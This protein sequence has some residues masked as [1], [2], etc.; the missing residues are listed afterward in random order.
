MLQPKGQL[1]RPPCQGRDV[2]VGAAT[3]DIATENGRG[4]TKWTH[5]IDPHIDRERVWIQSDLLFSGTAVAYR[6][7]ERPDAPT[8]AS[9]AT[10]DEI[11]TD[12]K[13]TIVDLGASRDQKK[14]PALA[15]RPG[16]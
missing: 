15:P 7:V 1:P 13:I 9:N 6:D 3:H 2:W 14:I 4:Y 5:R 12:G 11:V 16:D 8:K 10:G